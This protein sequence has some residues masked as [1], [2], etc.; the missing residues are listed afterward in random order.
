MN[1]RRTG[2]LGMRSSVLAG[3]VL[4]AALG[5]GCQPGGGAAADLGGRLDGG[6][7]DGATADGGTADGGPPI[8]DE[9]A[10]LAG[11]N[12]EVATAALRMPGENML[13]G[14]LCGGCHRQGGQAARFPWTISGTVFGS[15]SSSC[16][17][18]GLA[19]V[20]VEIFEGTSVTPKL[21]LTTNTA[22][23]FYSADPVAF[24]IRARLSKDGKTAEMFGMMA[25]GACATCHQ[26]PGIAGAPGRIFLN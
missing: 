13:P 24:P 9:T 8:V 21:T 2:P 7:A 6:T 26:N 16:N 10:A 14:R 4:A 23:S 3:V 18:G 22:G 5:G 12:C 1:I 25:T 19:G 11:A 20:K 15:P 17:P